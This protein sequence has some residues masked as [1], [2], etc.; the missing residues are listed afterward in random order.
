MSQIEDLEAI[1]AYFKRAN[2][3]KPGVSA[4]VSDWNRWYSGLGY[5]SKY[6]NSGTLDEARRR[7]GALNAALGTPENPLTSEA[8]MTEAEKQSYLDKPVVNVTGMT[9]EAANKAAW[10]AKDSGLSGT[11]NA[12]GTAKKRATLRIGSTGADVKEWQSII[13]VTVDGKFGP[14]TQAATKVWQTAHGLKA[15]GVVGPQTWA[16]AVASTAIPSTGWLDPI[17]S[18]VSPKNPT[19]ISSSPTGGTTPVVK[20]TEPAN[21]VPKKAEE[22]AVVITSPT[23]PSTASML[24]ALSSLPTWGKITLG[25][26]SVAG[27]TYGIKYTA[28][29]RR[30]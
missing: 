29:R 13:K 21:T 26:L 5:I 23:Q 16:A 2:T 7:R 24:P 8:S 9:K 20:P 15:D 4:I 14:G 22:K 3:S 19:V 6:A 28:E 17:L 30:Y 1:D 25:I 11:S 12:I 27:L 10:T 18:I